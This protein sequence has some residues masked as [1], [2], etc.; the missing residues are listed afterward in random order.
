MIAGRRICSRCRARSQTAVAAAIVGQLLPRERTALITG[1]PV[2]RP[3][4]SQPISEVGPLLPKAS[5]TAGALAALPT[6]GPP[7]FESDTALDVTI[8]TDL[9]RLIQTP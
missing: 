7:I 1:G 6:L 2:P 4:L 3:A 5:V 8:T 9:A